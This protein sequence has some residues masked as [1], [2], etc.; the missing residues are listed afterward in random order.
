MRSMANHKSLD[1]R[2][3]AALTNEK[4]ALG[5]L[6]NFMVLLNLCKVSAAI[7]QN[8]M[9]QNMNLIFVHDFDTI[10][11]RLLYYMAHAF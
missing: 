8:H 10:E 11:P 4:C 3:K 6:R 7:Y 1:R 9:R 2:H 5:A